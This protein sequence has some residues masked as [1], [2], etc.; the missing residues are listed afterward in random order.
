VTTSKLDN[1]I[2]KIEHTFETEEFRQNPFNERDWFIWESRLNYNIS[3]YLFKGGKPDE[4]ALEYIR[5]KTG[6]AVS[7]RDRDG[8]GWYVGNICKVD[9]NG[10]DKTILFG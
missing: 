5:N 9:Q 8:L 4:D 6:W 10:D 3:K 1:L 2:K 7:A